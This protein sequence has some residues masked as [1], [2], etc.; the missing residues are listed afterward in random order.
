MVFNLFC[1][2]RRKLL[3]ALLLTMLPASMSLAQE[4]AP[5]D[6]VAA[7]FPQ[8]VDWNNA[9]PEQMYSA[10]Y[11]AVKNNP[12]ATLDIVQSSLNNIERTGRYP[13]AGNGGGKEVI[14]DDGQPRT[15]EDMALEVGKAATAANPAMT[16]SIANLIN[17]LVPTLPT[18][19]IVDSIT[20][21]QPPPTDPGGS[22]G[23]GTPGIFLPS[24]SG[25]GGGGGGIPSS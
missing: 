19:M 20:G 22:G 8:G 15:F 1:P 5:S 2:M 7:I 9:T 6:Q 12:D 21:A 24:G 23:G 10:I 13:R 14:E 3:K 4:A 17:G 16:Q 18:Q 11:N 25:G